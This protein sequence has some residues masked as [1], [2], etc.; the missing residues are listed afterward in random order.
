MNDATIYKVMKD[1]M[2]DVELTIEFEKNKILD[3]SGM[4]NNEYEIRKI[5]KRFRLPESIMYIG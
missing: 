5:E 4:D 2:A 1:I 3:A